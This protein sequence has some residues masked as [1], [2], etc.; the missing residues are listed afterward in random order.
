MCGNDYYII[1]FVLEAKTSNQY[2][3]ETVFNWIK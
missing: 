3:D 2:A 1:A